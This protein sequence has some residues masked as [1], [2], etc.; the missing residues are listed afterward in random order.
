MNSIDSLIAST[1][2]IKKY[3][4]ATRNI[5][6]YPDERTLIVIIH[7]SEVKVFL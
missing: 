1:A 7:L 3:K 5:K 6:H 2:M 4:I